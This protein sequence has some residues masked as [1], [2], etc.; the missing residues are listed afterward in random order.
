[1]NWIAPSEK[2]TATETLEKRLLAAAEQAVPAPNPG[3]TLHDYAGGCP[4]KPV[5][6]L[7]FLRYGEVRVAAQRA[8]LEKAGASSRR[9]SR[10]DEPTTYHAKGTLYLP[11]KARFDYLLI[12]ETSRLDNSRC[13]SR[14]MNRAN[15]PGVHRKRRPD[16]LFVS[17]ARFVAEQEKY[18]AAEPAIDGVEKTDETG[19]LCCLVPVWKDLSVHG[20]EGDL[21]HG[22]K[23]SSY[24]DD[25]H[26]ATGRF[27]LV[28]DTAMRAKARIAVW[29]HDRRKFAERGVSRIPTVT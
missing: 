5:L 6:G 24:Y 23:V 19:R 4:Q 22:G 17:P 13:A 11:A 14:E 21:R 16:R 15:S 26:D 3:R 27:D 28:L 25:P 10:A 18:S 12:F 29:K 7:I 2:D 9:G 20:L 1:M 8:K